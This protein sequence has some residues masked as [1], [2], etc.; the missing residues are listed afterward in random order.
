MIN[1]RK[2]PWDVHINVIDVAADVHPAKPKSL[3]SMRK[4]VADSSDDS[5][6]CMK[7]AYFFPFLI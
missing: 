5:S 6:L 4:W 2:Y 3:I 7:H 1:Y